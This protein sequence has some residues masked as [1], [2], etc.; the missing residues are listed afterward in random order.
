MKTKIFMAVVA[1]LLVCGFNS[2]SK[3]E[4]F[5]VFGSIYGSVVDDTSGEPI[6]GATITLSPSGRTQT[7]GT[8]GMFEFKDVDPMQY[9]VTVQKPGYNTNR[10]II[11]VDAGDPTG[12]NVSLHKIN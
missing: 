6:S 11:K 4:D 3:D 2:C 7:S 8:D 10:K 1:L 12:A 5:N 9:T